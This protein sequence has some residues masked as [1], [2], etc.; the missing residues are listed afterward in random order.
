MKPRSMLC[1]GQG[2]PQQ[3]ELVAW[4]FTDVAARRQECLPTPERN[5]HL[6]AHVQKHT[7]LCAARDA[8]S[9]HQARR[10]PTSNH[11][12]TATGRG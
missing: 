3:C 12:L 8:Y 1:L 11:Q 2:L 4:S 10:E 6:L 7:F 5:F 9:T